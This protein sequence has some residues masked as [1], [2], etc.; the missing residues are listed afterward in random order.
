[1]K[2]MVFSVKNL[3]RALSL[4]APLLAMIYLCFSVD[5][6]LLY[7]LAP[8]FIGSY[9]IIFIKWVRGQQIFEDTL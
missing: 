3:Y 9:L 4:L 1:M 7:I 5:R 8:I 2:N 6:Q